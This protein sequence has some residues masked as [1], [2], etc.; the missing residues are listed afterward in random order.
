MGYEHL[1]RIERIYGTPSCLPS[2]VLLIVYS[3]YTSRYGGAQRVIELKALHD[4]AI[5]KSSSDM[6]GTSTVPHLDAEAARTAYRSD[7]A[8]PCHANNG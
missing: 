3:Y 6:T 2:Q 7:S 4:S 5:Q 1:E 8:C